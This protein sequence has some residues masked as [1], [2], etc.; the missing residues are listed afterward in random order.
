MIF[1]SLETPALG[2]RDRAVVWCALIVLIAL[3]W[4]Y[5]FALHKEM[6]ALANGG[7]SAAELLRT[8]TQ[9]W[10]AADVLFTF[11]MWFVMMIGMMAGSAAPML[12]LFAATEARRGSRISLA[13]ASFGAG[14][15]AVWLGFSALA[16]LAQWALHNAGLLSP[17][18]VTTEPRVGGA[19]L[20]VA[21]VYQLTPLKAACLALCRSPLGFMMTHWRDGRAGAWRMGL[22]HGLHCLGCCWALMGVLF[23]VGVMNLL[24]VAA[25][26]LLV[27]LEKVGFAPLLV[28]RATGI[29]LV[30]AGIRFLVG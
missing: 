27:L 12:L 4:G 19:I 9:P 20:L 22:A 16:T 17:L 24:W 15:L 5:L 8:M 26:T 3:S 23:V 14:Y 1:D 21:G 30:A 25:L 6:S 11:A 18:M 29:A 7:A 10:Q 13:V 28:A 2:A